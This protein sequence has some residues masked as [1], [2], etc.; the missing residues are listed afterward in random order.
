[1][2]SLE[3]LLD[4]YTTQMEK[5]QYL[6][7]MSVKMIDPDYMR[8]KTEALNGA[9]V[10]IYGG[11]YLGVQL[12]KSVDGLLNVV[13][14]VDKSGKLKWNIPDIPV[15]DIEAFR[16]CYEDEYVIIT[17]INFYREIWTELSKFISENRLLPLS[18]LLGDD[19]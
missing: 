6:H 4:Y 11:G 13:S 18:E 2:E 3:K 1:M 14:I 17:P 15:M 10:Y 7:S 8:Q 16:S 12:F 19:L 5:E 9:D